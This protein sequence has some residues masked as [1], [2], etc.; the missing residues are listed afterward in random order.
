MMNFASETE[1]DSE[2]QTRLFCYEFSA[3]YARREKTLRYHAG[4]KV[5]C[6]NYQLKL[7][8]LFGS[9][10]RNCDKHGVE[11]L[12]RGIHVLPATPEE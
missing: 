5:I 7:I 11:R 8:V 4:Y 3:L 6:G 10:K 1:T 2:V 12:V 9:Y